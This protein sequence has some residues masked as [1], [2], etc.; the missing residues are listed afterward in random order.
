MKDIT[1]TAILNGNSEVCVNTAHKLTCPEYAPNKSILRAVFAMF[2]FSLMFVTSAQ[3]VVDLDY[4]YFND[5]ETINSLH[6]DTDSNPD[7]D[8]NGQADW[9]T[10]NDWSITGEHNAW[11]NYSGAN[12]LDN[13]AAEVDQYGNVTDQ[14]ASLIHYINIPTDSQQPTLSYFYKLNLTHYNDV[15]YVQVQIEGET[16]WTNLKSYVDQHNRDTFAREMI[17]LDAYK[18]KNIRIRFKQTDYWTYGVRMFVVDDFKIADLDLASYEYPF[19]NNFETEAE[20][21]QWTTSGLFTIR[22]E[23]NAWTNNDGVAHLD[24]NPYEIDQ[25]S[26]NADQTATLNGYVTIPN[27]SD[28]PT[29]YYHYKLNLLHYNDKVELQVQ[30]QGESNWTTLKTYQEQHNQSTYTAEEIALD[31]YKG[32]S[33]RLRFKQDG[34]WTNGTRLF[35]V[36]TLSIANYQLPVFS[37]PYNSGF[38]TATASQWVEAG[39]WGIVGDHNQWTNKS[40]SYHLDNNPTEID[41]EGYND[42]QLVTLDGY[43]QIPDTSALPTLTFWYKLGLLHYNDKIELQVQ[44]LEDGTDWQTL[45][46]YEQQHN[47]DVYTAEEISIEAFKGT[48]IRLRFKQTY[49]SSGARLFVVDDLRVGDL[50]L[51]SIAYPYSTDF[52]DTANHDQWQ[53][54]SSWLITGEHNNWTNLSGV[55]HLDNNANENSQYGYITDH[56]ATLNGLIEIPADSEAPALRYGYKL[57]L[58]HYN[59]KVQLQIQTESSADW[60]TL[61]EYQEQHNHNVY[62][63]DDISLSAYKD[64]KIRLRFR[65]TD[66]WTNGSRLFVV[67][68]LDVGELSLTQFGFPYQTD[69]DEAARHNEWDTQG[70]WSIS[71]AHGSWGNNSGTYHLD[72]NAAEADL[73]AHTYGHQATLAGFITVPLG[74]Q[75][76]VLSLSQHI[77]LT[78]YQDV[79]QIQV[80]E[81]GTDTW[82]TLQEFRDTDNSSGYTQ[83]EI[84]LITYRGKDIRIRFNQYSGWNSGARVWAIDDLNVYDKSGVQDFDNDGVDDSVDQCPNTPAGETVNSNGCALS[85]LDSDNDGVTDDVDV[86]PN[87]PNESSDLDGDGIGDNADTDRDGDGVNNDQDTFPDDGS[88]SSDLDG[89]GIGDNADTDR[90]GDGVD[91]DQDSYPNDGTRTQLSAVEGVTT[92]QQGQAIVI[93]WTPHLETILQGYNLYRADY[94]QTNWQ[95]LNND[96][97]TDVSFT[98][99]TVVNGQAYQYRINAVDN[100]DIE[101]AASTISNQFVIYNNIVIDAANATAQWQNFAAQI[102]WTH[103]AQTNESY[104][105]YRAAATRTQIYAGANTQFTDSAVAWQQAHQYELVSVLSFTNPITA[106][107]ETS[108]GPVTNISLSALPAITVALAGVQ[109]VADNQVRMETVAGNQLS[110]VGRYSNAINDIQLTLTNSQGTTTTTGENGEFQF[111]V[112]DVAYEQMTLTLVENN[113]PADRG[114]TI[115]IDVTADQTPLS[116]IIDGGANQTTSEANFNLAGQV[117][118]V[119]QGIKTLT[120]TNSRF[121]EQTFGGILAEDNNFTSEVPLKTGDNT[122]TVQVEN[123][124]GQTAQN[125]IQVQREA[126]LLPSVEFTSH[127]NN[128]AVVEN[129]VT[130]VGRIYSALEASKIKLS[131]GDELATIT[132]IENQLYQFQVANIE[133]VDGYNEIIALTE[134]EV[135]NVTTSLVLYRQDETTD[136]PGVLSIQMTTPN[137]GQIINDDLLSV[138][139]QLFNANATASLTVNGESV[140]LFGN[141]LTGLSFNHS[142]N[143]SAISSGTFDINIAANADGLDAIQETITVNIDREAP[144]ITLT[145]TLTAPPAVNEIREQPYVISG[146]VTDANLSSLSINGQG[147]LLQ[148]AAGVNAYNF[149]TGLRLAEGEQTTVNVIATDLAGNESLVQYLFNANTQANIEIVQPLENTTHTTY[150]ATHDINFI[151]RIT[152]I[153]GVNANLIVTAGGTAQQAIAINQ[154][155]ITGVISINTADTINSIRFEVRDDSNELLAAKELPITLINGDTIPL[156]VEKTVPENGD[157]YYQPHHP[158]K[159]YFNKVVELDRVTVT[160]RETFHGQTYST[161]RISSAQLDNVYQGQLVEVHKNNEAVA[162]GLSLVPGERIVEFYPDKDISYGAQVFVDVSYDGTSLKR[163]A[164]NVRS[165]PTFVAGT[166]YNQIQQSIPNIEVSIPELKLTTLTDVHGTFSF[167]AGIK[168]ENNIK[169]GRYRVVVN[170]NGKNPK[171]GTTQQDVSVQAG[172][173]NNNKM[174]RI[175]ALDPSIAHNRIASGVSNTISS[176]NLVLDASQARFQFAHGESAGNV[177]VQRVEIGEMLYVP[178]LDELVPFWMYQIQP[179]GIK[180]VGDL[181]IEITAPSLYGSFD[182]LPPNGTYVVLAARDEKSLLIK[183]VGVAVVQD[184]KMISQGKVHLDRLDYIGYVFVE[185]DNKTQSILSDYANGQIN[186]DGLI[187]LIT[188]E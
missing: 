43:I 179:Q 24:N 56:T 174:I 111:V 23:H 103:A 113:A 78:H 123:V 6:D 19:Y 98:D 1:R 48:H 131:I 12:H 142:I 117:I 57:G 133:L 88:E 61:K 51:N 129:K 183:P 150:G 67:D 30:L 139:G 53:L 11:T 60:T 5:F 66:F 155:I 25:Y 7:N 71:T 135:G 49:W 105:L 9:E 27:D 152:G 112:R 18:G 106:L 86:F 46:T 28:S 26:Y 17:S 118:N 62:T 81:K 143:L 169:T 116:V 94:G 44:V 55:Y 104:R 126:E 164:Y 45:K 180:V 138:R 15:I 79:L 100:N 82:E 101:G 8:I 16:N 171:Y 151:S 33:I 170:E 173:L 37:Y 99:S 42:N 184:G 34:F 121:A 136:T 58:L 157:K 85:Q 36:D 124:L 63:K 156:S 144:Q 122:I 77:T 102:N 146:T 114:H 89:D 22:D 177:H 70:R 153:T 95:A 59:D 32:Q 137:S 162:G 163:F 20:Q 75:E 73:Y 187:S 4:P 115:T 119:D 68:D 3:A 29:L 159:L 72:S 39:T 2:V 168:P 108:E 158:I 52:E 50:Q 128:Q 41:Q 80:Q 107:V 69:F 186:I 141:P 65:Q 185:N 181:Q 165:R 91:N 54:A 175:A 74:S 87:D 127:A 35:V 97:L 130:L 166:V 145:N 84:S 182:Y 47:H 134:T 96:L 178:A 21:S 167:G 188:Q 132:E 172:V 120:I 109:Q 83:F 176:G 64:Q 14:D 76:P 92:Q 38:E 140:A 154:D 93:N 160:V 13:N 147:L 10:L 40:G 125:S 148:P 149:N 31:A 110:I 90:D 161:E